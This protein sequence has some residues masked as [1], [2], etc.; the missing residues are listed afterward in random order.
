MFVFHASLK[1]KVTFLLFFLPFSTSPLVV[2]QTLPTNKKLEQTRIIVSS[3]RKGPESCFF[4]FLLLLFSFT[5]N[6]AI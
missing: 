1:P 6:D 3:Q 4:F 2:G 5:V